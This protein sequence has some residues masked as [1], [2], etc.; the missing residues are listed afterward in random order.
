MRAGAAQSANSAKRTVSEPLPAPA[1][2]PA[3]FDGTGFLDDLAD[4]TAPRT[5]LVSAFYRSFPE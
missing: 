2:G 3:L 5:P 4:S 1:S